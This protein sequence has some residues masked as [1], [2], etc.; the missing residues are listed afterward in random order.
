MS[1]GCQQRPHTKE[2]TQVKGTRSP[3]C[4]GL[5]PLKIHSADQQPYCLL[6]TCETSRI[7]GP[8]QDLQ[9]QSPHLTKPLNDAYATVRLEKHRFH[10]LLPVQGHLK[11]CSV[12]CHYGIYNL[13]SHV[14]DLLSQNS[15]SSHPYF[16]SFFFLSLLI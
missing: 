1:A 9:N 6:G 5:Q 15:L 12:L 2:C 13:G 8:A 7:V 10:F 16:L 3:K 14:F 4:S 11:R